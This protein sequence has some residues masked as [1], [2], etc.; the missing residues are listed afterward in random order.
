MAHED[1]GRLELPDN[2]FEK[3]HDRGSSQAFH[4]RMVAIECFDFDLKPWI[5]WSEH[6]I[7]LGFIA[8]N[9]MFPASRRYPE[10]MNQHDG[11]GTFRWRGHGGL[12]VDWDLPGLPTL[13]T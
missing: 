6:A 7:A 12:L 10:A 5:R 11:I 3:C 2:G 8:C 9:P 13:A 4:R 1:R